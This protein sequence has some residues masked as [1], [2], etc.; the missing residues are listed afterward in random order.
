MKTFWVCLASACLWCAGSARGEDIIVQCDGTIAG[1]FG[2]LDKVAIRFGLPQAPPE[3]RWQEKQVLHTLWVTNGIQYRQTVLLT[4]LSREAKPVGRKL[5][6]LVNIAGE[7]TNSTYAEATA[8]LSIEISGRPQKLELSG[9]IVWRITGEGRRLFGALDI[10]ESGI[11]QSCGERLLFC[12]NMPPSEKGSMTLKIPLERIGGQREC[13][14]LTDLVFAEELQRV[15]KS[16]ANG[17]SDQGE[18][19]LLFAPD[20]G[21]SVP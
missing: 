7:N 9:G 18:A 21:G 3:K 11:K 17:R 5:A 13:E 4:Q 12:G 20:R 8:E 15:R 10:P 1:R 2:G 19:R 6:L 16:Q 14:E